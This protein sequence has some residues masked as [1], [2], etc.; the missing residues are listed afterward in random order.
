[1]TARRGTD[2]DTD[3]PGAN[4]LKTRVESANSFPC[5]SFVTYWLRIALVMQNTEQP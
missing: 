4:C 2:R 1:M 5:S 3:P